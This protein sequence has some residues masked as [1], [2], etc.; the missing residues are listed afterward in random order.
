MK[1]ERVSKSVLLILVLGISLLFLTMI[2]QYLM[3]IFMAGLLSAMINPVHSWMSSR[4]GGRG[5]LASF[6][7]ILGMVLLVLIPMA[8]LMGVV[9]SQAISVGQS[10]TP[11]IQGFINEPG[12]LSGYIEKIPYHNYILEYRNVL[13][14]RAGLIVGNISSFLINSLSSVTKMTVNAVFN[15]FIMLYVMFFFL[16]SGK[17]FLHKIL[18]YLPLHDSDEQVLLHRF[19]SVAGATMKGTLIIG[20]MQGSICGLAFGLAGIHG[21]VFWGS[22]MAVMSII[23]AFGTAVIWFPALVI[24]ALAGDFKA[25]FILLIICGGVA[26][27][28]DN[29]VRPRLV[30]KDTEM[31]ELFVLFSTLGGIGMFGLLGI[32]IGP[33]IAALFITLWEMYGKVFQ[34]FLPEVGGEAGSDDSE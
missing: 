21:P 31:H 1:R 24:M 25:V 28:L 17:A 19:T 30:G 33:I 14:A 20:I 4:L 8:V 29:L 9:V 26:G 2:R 18:Y 3:P 23:P 15:G 5:N 11:W 34:D 13:V 16:S 6:L 7:V 10:V 27:N 12:L 22:I 32:I